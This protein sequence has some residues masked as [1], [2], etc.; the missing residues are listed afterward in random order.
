M[1]AILAD[2]LSGAAELAGIAA[3]RGYAAEVHTRFDP[4]STADV[5]A[6]DT[7][8]RLMQEAEAV[9]VLKGITRQ[10][11][12]TQ[13]EWI[14]KKT[15]SVLRGHVRAEIETILSEGHYENALLIPAN[16]SKGRI[17][18][19]GTYLIDGIP[20]DQTLFANDPDH[21]RSSAMV[22]ELLGSSNAISI[23][24]IEIQKDLPTSV[25]SNVLPAGAADFF[26]SLL[27]KR[28]TQHL[29]EQ[30]E[31][32]LLLCGSIAAWESGRAEE[33]K[34]RGF[35]VRTLEEGGG[36]LDWEKNT[37]L[38]LAIGKPQHLSPEGLIERLIR[39]ALPLIE[40]TGDLRIAMEGGAT[41]MA[42]IREMNWETL[43][44]VAEG[45]L[46]VG[47]LR[48]GSGP[49]LSIKPGSYPW[50]DSLFA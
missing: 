28:E 3:S 46:G 30:A 14:Y 12:K 44:I 20:L 32:I 37:R 11:M 1:I 41:A 48:S 50:P 7:E 21:P 2:D 24:D 6:I 4:R 23:P 31:R 16:P 25:P 42:L 15:D 43:S 38:M 18:R 34:A 45:H 29:P 10:L 27:P 47:S 36:Q 19:D 39:A 40:T 17:I 33:M 26:S 9:E 49:L 13:P 22:R 8:T 35:T 5:I